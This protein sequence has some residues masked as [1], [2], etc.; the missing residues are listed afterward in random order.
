MAWMTAMGSSINERREAAGYSRIDSPE[1][2][3]TTVQSN[4]VPVTDFAAGSNE[5]DPANDGTY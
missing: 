2:D 1:M 3:V 5:P 4:L